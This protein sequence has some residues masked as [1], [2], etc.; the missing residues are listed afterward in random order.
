MHKRFITANELL[1]D[2]YRLAQ[3]IYQSGFV[4]DF[5]VGVWRGGT[6]VAIAVEEFL[7]YRGI[8]TQHAAIKTASYTGINEQGVVKVSGLEALMTAEQR[9][10]RLLIVDD[11]FDSGRSIAAILSQLAQQSALS[12]KPYPTEVKIACPWYKPSRN[13]TDNTPDYY[14]HTTEDWLVFPHELVGLS[15]AEII[16]G[17]GEA[18]ASILRMADKSQT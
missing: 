5:V 8:N 1:L 13:V 10:E 4:P 7:T 16:D 17:K 9:P 14:L 2:A 15:E 11:V 12:S 18:V 3:R 6:P